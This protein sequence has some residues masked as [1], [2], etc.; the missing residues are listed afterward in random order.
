MDWNTLQIGFHC[1][2]LTV[3]FA[4]AGYTVVQLIVLSVNYYKKIRPILFLEPPPIDAPDVRKI[5]YWNKQDTAIKLQKSFFKLF[6]NGIL[7]L[8]ATTLAII[9]NWIVLQSIT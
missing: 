3:L 6:K 7:V 8:I 1:A 4:M 5:L 2:F 9:C